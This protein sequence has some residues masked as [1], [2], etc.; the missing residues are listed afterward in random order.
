MVELF[1]WKNGKKNLKVYFKLLLHRVSVFLIYMNL[2]CH[3]FYIYMN[4]L[5]SLKHDVLMSSVLG[6]KLSQ[7]C[8]ELLPLKL[9]NELN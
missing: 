8:T 4:S 9:M 2:L 7:V 6:D 5:N 1:I 3:F